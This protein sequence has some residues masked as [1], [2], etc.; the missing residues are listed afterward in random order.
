MASMR[1]NLQHLSCV[2]KFLFLVHAL[3]I[4]A[5]LSSSFRYKRVDGSYTDLLMSLVINGYS[6]AFPCPDFES[7]EFSVF[8]KWLTKKSKKIL[9]NELQ[10]F[11]QRELPTSAFALI[12]DGYSKV[13][14]RITLRL[15]KLLVMLS[16]VST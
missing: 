12:I 15:N 8:R 4:S 1:E 2:L 7:F 3:R 11:K 5:L 16:L 6:W 13:K 10:L 14:L 9:K